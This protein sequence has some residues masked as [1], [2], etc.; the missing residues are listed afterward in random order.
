MPSIRMKLEV[1][2][3]LDRCIS[4]PAAG[5]LLKEIKDNINHSLLGWKRPDF[6]LG[7]SIRIRTTNWEFSPLSKES[8]MQDEYS[9][10]GK[11]GESRP[12]SKAR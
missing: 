9:R 5:S 2:V 7:E 12:S 10:S 4:D 1:I 8:K 3:E 11:D 6:L